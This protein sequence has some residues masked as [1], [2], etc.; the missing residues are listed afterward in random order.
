MAW[1]AMAHG[2]AAA[3][4]GE[5]RARPAVTAI[6][7]EE[8]CLSAAAA[9]RGEAGRLIAGTLAEEG[10]EF[11]SGGAGAKFGVTHDLADGRRVLGR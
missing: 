6:G 1:Q 10:D 2:V 11:E 9:T 8:P 3:D 5:L 4:R 7:V